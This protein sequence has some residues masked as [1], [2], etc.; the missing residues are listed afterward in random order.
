[1]TKIR[2][3]EATNKQFEQASLTI[4]ERILKECHQLYTDPENGLVI[5][6]SNNHFP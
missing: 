2:H 4:N 1:M 6:S 3:R 5:K